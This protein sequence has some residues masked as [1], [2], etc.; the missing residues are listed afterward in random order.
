MT[1]VGRDSGDGERRH[2]AVG[3]GVELESLEDEL[4]LESMDGHDE[5][6]GRRGFSRVVWST[7]FDPAGFARGL[8]EC[9]FVLVFVM[10]KG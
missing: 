4:L 2:R 1:I 3:E 5:I 7:P 9:L 6:D 8:K 10:T